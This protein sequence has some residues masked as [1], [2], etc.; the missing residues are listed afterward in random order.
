MSNNFFSNT[1]HSF[2]L[3]GVVA[4]PLGVG[5][6]FICISCLD[7]S[8][9]VNNVGYKVCLGQPSPVRTILFPLKAT[10]AP[11]VLVRMSSTSGKDSVPSK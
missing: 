8:W 2:Q 5:Y 3:R 9:S 11:A 7:R 6:F 1:R 10:V 4:S